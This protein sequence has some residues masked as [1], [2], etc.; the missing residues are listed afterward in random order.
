MGTACKQLHRRHLNKPISISYNDEPVDFQTARDLA[1]E[2]AR[3]HGSDPM[4]LAWFDRKRQRYSPQ[5][6]C[7][8]E[9][10]PSWLVYAESRGGDIVVDINDLEYVFIFCD[11]HSLST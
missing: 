1:F 4:L 5:V 10:K 9:D 11:S 6:E 7:C 8:G 3:Q 2:V